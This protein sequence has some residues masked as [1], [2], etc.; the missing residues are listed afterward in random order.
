M[1]DKI[2]TREEAR[3]LLGYDDDA[4]NGDGDDDDEK[5]PPKEKAPRRR[6]GY[7]DQGGDK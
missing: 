5:D 6:A 7:F 1:R 3:K 2:L 4:D